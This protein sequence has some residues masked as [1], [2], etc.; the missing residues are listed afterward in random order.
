M[1]GCNLC[2]YYGR[3]GLYKHLCLHPSLPEPYELTYYMA[4][5]KG[6]CKN[7]VSDEYKTLPGHEPLPA[8]SAYRY[9]KEG[10]DG[11]KSD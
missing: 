11:S 10:E 2:R 3:V 4:G 8:P 1:D 9:R 5:G 6:S 7:F